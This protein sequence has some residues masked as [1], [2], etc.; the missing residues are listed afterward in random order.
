MLSEREKRRYSRQIILPDVGEKGQEALKAGKVMVV[1]AGGLGCPV[2][3]YLAA[4]G[5]GKIG[6]VEFD[7]VSESNIHRQILYGSR[8]VGKL[9]SIIAKNILEKI[10]DLAVIEIFNLRLTAGN[11][12]RILSGWDIIID[13][14]DNYETRY[15]IDRFCSEGGIPMIHGAIYMHE[16]QVSVFNHRG[17]GSYAYYHPCDETR[18][19]NPDPSSVGLF[20]V[21]P[22]TTGSIM[23]SEAIKL[24]TGTGEVLAGKLLTFN[25]MNNSFITIDLPLPGL[26][27]ETR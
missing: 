17:A 24:I 3:Q 16:G 12:S 26:K 10:N 11:A 23:A 9:K 4:A 2:L 20:G 19:G 7:Q 8:D 13:A 21:L 6:I 1:G 15:V 22:G 14:T 27:Q 25:T 5:V 18:S